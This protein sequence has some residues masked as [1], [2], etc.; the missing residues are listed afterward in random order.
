MPDAIGGGESPEQ[1]GRGNSLWISGPPSVRGEDRGKRMAT[2]PFELYPVIAQ[3]AGAFAGFG[4]L[5]GGLGRRR[6]ADDARIDASRLGTMLHTSLSATMFG[7]IP[8]TLASLSVSERWSLGVPAIASVT[9]ILIFGSIGVVRSLRIRHVSGFSRG[10][11]I[12]NSACIL[13]SVCAFALCSI[14]IPSD[15]LAGLYLLGLMGLLGSSVVMFSRVI[16]SMLRA[17]RETE[18]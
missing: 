6:G 4:S 14:G 18:A 17:H 12:A 1:G 2:D 13:T 7:L 10:A 16:V 11:T 15:R 3:I 8:A 5:A 9:M